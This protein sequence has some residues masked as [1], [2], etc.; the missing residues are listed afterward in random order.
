MPEGRS[1]RA[2]TTCG[3]LR[4]FS[5]GLKFLASAFLLFSSGHNKS[6]SRPSSSRP[7]PKTCRLL[8]RPPASISFAFASPRGPL[9][10]GRS[11][12]PAA[13]PKCWRRLLSPGFSPCFSASPLAHCLRASRRRPFLS[14]P[15]LALPPPSPSPPPLPPSPAPSLPPRPRP[16]RCLHPPTSAGRAMPVPPRSL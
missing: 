6:R 14:T 5:H 8:R 1:E 13:P 11:L 7:S 16:R 10:F 9:T 3:L 15:W 12:L 2:R 4:K